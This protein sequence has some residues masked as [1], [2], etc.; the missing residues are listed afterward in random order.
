MT[1]YTPTPIRY[2]IDG[3]HILHEA[4]VL[5]GRPHVHALL[6]QGVEGVGARGAALASGAVVAAWQRRARTGT[7]QRAAACAEDSGNQS[8]C[9]AKKRHAGRQNLQFHDNSLLFHLGSIENGAEGHARRVRANV[10]AAH[11]QEKRQEQLCGPPV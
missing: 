3:E 2:L 1:R 9:N 5:P 4:G 8:T 6:E 10:L 11:R 7:V